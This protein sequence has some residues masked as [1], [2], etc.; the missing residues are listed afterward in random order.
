MNTKLVAIAIIALV[1]GGIATEALLSFSSPSPSDTATPTYVDS[2][3][4]DSAVFP[5]NTTITLYLRQ[6]GNT[7]A[8]LRSYKVTEDNGDS[9]SLT[10]WPTPSIPP[11]AAITTDIL[12]GSACPSCTVTGNPFT[13]KSGQTYSITVYASDG[14]QFSFQATRHQSTYSITLTVGFGTTGHP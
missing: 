5:S 8:T 10:A 3:V 12:I 1:V 2:I 11:S 13:F 7:T 14:N 4:M 6:I 9:Y